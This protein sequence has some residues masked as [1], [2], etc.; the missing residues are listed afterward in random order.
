MKDPTLID[1]L[2]HLTIYR[3]IYEIEMNII[4]TIQSEK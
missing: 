4:E 3:I 1:Y 2:P